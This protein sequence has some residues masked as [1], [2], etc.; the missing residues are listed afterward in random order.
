[1]DNK[2]P[3][4]GESGEQVTALLQAQVE[5]ERAVQAAQKQEQPHQGKTGMGESE[6]VAEVQGKP[7]HKMWRSGLILVGGLVVVGVAGWCLWWVIG[8][9]GAEIEVKKMEA[10]EVR[11]LPAGE[12]EVGASESVRRSFEGEAGIFEGD[13]GVMVEGGVVLEP[14]DFIIH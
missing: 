12:N 7:R 1:M 10:G 6:K 3:I 2:R 13:E 9:D 14:G 11:V 5:L 8:Q 4:I